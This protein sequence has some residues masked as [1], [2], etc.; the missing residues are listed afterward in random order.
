MPFFQGVRRDLTKTEAVDTL[1][2]HFES[3]SDSAESAEGHAID[4]AF[5]GGKYDTWGESQL[6]TKVRSH[7]ES[8]RRFYAEVYEKY[9]I[10]D[11]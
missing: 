6:R 7:R 4:S 3:L 1:K 5:L 8:G 2:S 9:I 11:S 10:D